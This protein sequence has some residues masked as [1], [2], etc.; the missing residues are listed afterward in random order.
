MKWVD[1]ARRERITTELCDDDGA[2]AKAEAHLANSSKAW[3]GNG[4]PFYGVANLRFLQHKIALERCK[5]IGQDS[6]D[7]AEALELAKKLILQAGEAIQQC[8]NNLDA[9][10]EDDAPS[11]DLKEKVGKLCIE[12]GEQNTA[13]KSALFE[14]AAK[15]LGECLLQNDQSPEL[16]L[17]CGLCHLSLNDPALALEE[18]SRAGQLFEAQAGQ[19]EDETVANLPPLLAQAKQALAELEDK[20][21][22]KDEEDEKDESDEDE[23]GESEFVGKIAEAAVAQQSQSPFVF[24][25]AANAGAGEANEEEDIDM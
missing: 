11:A 6:K 12:L 3:P 23:S 14:I 17:L 21:E 4:E 2:E 7:G 18:L 25:I 16:Y 24:H 9:C 19:W 13:W 10:G 22:Q 8:I 1:V 15:L 20:G 5:Q